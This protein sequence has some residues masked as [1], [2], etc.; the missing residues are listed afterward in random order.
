MNA[1]TVLTVDD[2]RWKWWDGLQV[3][4]FYPKG[5]RREEIDV[6]I[7]ARNN[8]FNG[9]VIAACKAEIERRKAMS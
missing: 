4:S 2:G 8:T 7:S 5:K 1:P 3:V 9:A 6:G